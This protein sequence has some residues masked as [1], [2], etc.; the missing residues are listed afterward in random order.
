MV[1]VITVVITSHVCYVKGKED[2]SEKHI[3]VLFVT[4]LGRKIKT[5]KNMKVFNYMEQVWKSGPDNCMIPVGRHLNL[6]SV[7]DILVLSLSL[8]DLNTLGTLTLSLTS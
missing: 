7:L 8:D 5:H 6:T 3:D 4:S 1:C 2:K